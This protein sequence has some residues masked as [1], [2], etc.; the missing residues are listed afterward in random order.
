MANLRTGT[1]GNYYGSLFSESE[2]LSESEMTVNAKYIY[3]ALTNNGWSIN[4]ISG[5][6]GNMQAE[7]TINSGRWQSDD[8]GNIS[9]GYGLVQWTPSTKYT[10]WCD[11]KGFSDPSEMDH[12]IS[13]ILYEVDNGIQWIQTDSYPFSF[14]EFSTST[15]TVSELAKAFLLCY[16]RPADQSES[17]QEYRS[18]LAKKWYQVLT[19][20][21]PTEPDP[22]YPTGTTSKRKSKYKFLLYAGKR[23]NTWIK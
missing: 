16:E 21:T 5:M 11:S 23:R 1:F 2:P 9:L 14:K 12:N 15:K 17:V 13:R 4:A 7:S 6:L 8:V 19:G 10:D 22:D 3:S 20:E 18:T